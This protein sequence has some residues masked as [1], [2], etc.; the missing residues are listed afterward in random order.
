MAGSIESARV[1]LKKHPPKL[2]R[3]TVNL[4]PDQYRAITA[5]A[6][7]GMSTPAEIFRDMLNMRMYREMYLDQQ[8]EVRT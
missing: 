3:V 5:Y 1:R 7:Q 6:E 4:D 8:E 2:K